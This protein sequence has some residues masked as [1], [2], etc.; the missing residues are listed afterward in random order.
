M[1]SFLMDPSRL[2][3]KSRRGLSDL[4]AL[5]S[6]SYR[7]FPRVCVS[8]FPHRRVRPARQFSR[9][10]V[11][12]FPQVRETWKQHVNLREMSR[13]KR[14][15]TR[16]CGYVVVITENEVCPILIDC[17]TS[18]VNHVFWATFI[19]EE[20]LPSICVLFFGVLYWHV[21]KSKKLDPKVKLE[22]KLLIIQLAPVAIAKSLHAFQQLLYTTFCSHPSLYDVEVRLTYDASFVFLI[23]SIPL[24]FLVEKSHFIMKQFF[25]PDQIRLIRSSKISVSY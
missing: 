4:S 17:Y 11:T 22:E 20:C 14:A 3:W 25:P 7:Q 19:T 13:E 15:Q 18:F 1:P 8:L 23:Y 9:V 24:S 10:C 16:T 5:S 6:P 2:L 12:L 21:N